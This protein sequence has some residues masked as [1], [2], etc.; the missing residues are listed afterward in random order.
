[1][2]GII[3][4]HLRADTRAADTTGG[5]TSFHAI[6]PTKWYSM[7]AQTYFSSVSTVPSMLL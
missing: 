4:G 2:R 3:G 7:R 5:G 1:M 6:G